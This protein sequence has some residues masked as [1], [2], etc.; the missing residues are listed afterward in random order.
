MNSRRLIGSPDREEQPY[1]I[2]GLLRHSKIPQ[3]TSAWGSISTDR[4]LGRNA[5][6][7][8]DHTVLQM[9]SKKA[10]AISWATA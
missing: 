3:L 6:V 4:P 7:A 2:A 8:L 1:H 9:W 10:T 5:G